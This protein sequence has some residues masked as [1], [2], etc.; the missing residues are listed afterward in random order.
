MGNGS[1]NLFDFDLA[2]CHVLSGCFHNKAFHG[3]GDLV[4]H[5]DG[6]DGYD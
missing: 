4:R 2:A 3:S 5:D 1:G 6:G